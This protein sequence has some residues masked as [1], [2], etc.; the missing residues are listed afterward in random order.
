M[1]TLVPS[2]VRNEGVFYLFYS[3][4]GNNGQISIGLAT[5]EDGLRFEKHPGNPILT[6]REKGFDAY[7][8]SG[9]VFFKADSCWIM[10]YNAGETALYGP[11]PYIGR[12]TAKE[13]AGPW[14]RM[15]HPVLTRGRPGEWDGGYVFPSA[16]FKTEDGSFWLYYSGGAAFWE[17]PDCHI[18]LAT[19]SDGIHW[20]KYNDPETNDHP[21]MD[22]DPVCTMNESENRIKDYEWSACILKTPEGYEMYYA[23][24]TADQIND[25]SQI[26]YAH[27]SDGFHW[28]KYPGSPIFTTEDDPFAKN[29]PEAC[30]FEFPSLVLTDSMCFMYY[31]YGQRIKSI[32]VATAHR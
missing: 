6:F 16:V 14:D 10:Y 25:L 7:H 9:P 24:K 20:I 13:L 21:C 4:W 3:G 32:G 27:S 17:K 18:G 23:F 31:D 12:A 22:S 8:V 11:G 29:N 15:D 19:S 2:A 1:V 5:S 26:R 28:E 30:F